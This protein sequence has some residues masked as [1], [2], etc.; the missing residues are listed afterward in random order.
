MNWQRYSKIEE[1][2]DILH[3]HTDGQ[4]NSGS[5]AGHFMAAKNKNITKHK[6]AKKKDKLNPKLNKTY[7]WAAPNA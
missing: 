2:S 1:F 6:P 3:G 5:L 7:N 4:D